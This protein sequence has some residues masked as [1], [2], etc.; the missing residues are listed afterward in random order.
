MIGRAASGL[1]L[2]T[3]ELEV[4]DAINKDLTDDFASLAK[5][6]KTTATG[7]PDGVSVDVSGDDDDDDEEPLDVVQGLSL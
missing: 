2:K 1:T 3:E 4:A 7:S 6:A 5:R